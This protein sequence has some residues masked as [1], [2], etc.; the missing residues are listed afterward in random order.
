MY[1]YC[2]D[3]ITE[4]AQIS[5]QIKKVQSGSL[6]NTL[7]EFWLICLM[8][9]GKCVLFVRIGLVAQIAGIEILSSWWSWCFAG[10][11]L[12]WVSINVH[13]F[14][15][16]W[17]FYFFS[18]RETS[19]DSWDSYDCVNYLIIFNISE[20]SQ[21]CLAVGKHSNALLTPVEEKDEEHQ[22]NLEAL[23]WTAGQLAGISCYFDVDQRLRA[24]KLKYVP[25]QDRCK[26]VAGFN[27]SFPLHLHKRDVG[28]APFQGRRPDVVFPSFVPLW[29]KQVE[30][31]DLQAQW[32]HERQ[33]LQEQKRG[34][35]WEGQ[36][37]RACCRR[38][39]HVFWY[40]WLLKML[41]QEGF[42]SAGPS[43]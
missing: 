19:R 6:T 26:E 8:R 36:R 39:L 35:A 10:Q 32:Q 38:F 11:V 31:Q 15:G 9:G 13:W 23:V 14:R 5:R 3:Q 33:A 18:F 25:K 37:S 4:T 7:V 41:S 27:A 20:A 17:S 16:I 30:I 29:D 34:K 1:R 21:S 22:K 43:T 2:K 40:H 42:H 24:T 28:V 12:G